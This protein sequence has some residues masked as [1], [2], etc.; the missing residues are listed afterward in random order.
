MLL[1]SVSLQLVEPSVADS[2][3]KSRC[4]E[5]DIPYF[6]LNPRLEQVVEAGETDTKVLISM[7]I[8]TSKEMNKQ[9]EMDKL[10][11]YFQSLP[12]AARTM[13][14]PTSGGQ[15]S[16]TCPNASTTVDDSRST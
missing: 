9:Q 15:E 16:H 8:Q 2:N 10:V 14:S 6:R 7:I 1:V 4:E 12:E 3:C 13:H 11:R 5:Q